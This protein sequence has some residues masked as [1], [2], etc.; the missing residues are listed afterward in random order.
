MIGTFSW[1]TLQWVHCKAKGMYGFLMWRYCVGFLLCGVRRLL[2]ELALNR[3][4][5]GC[6]SNTPLSDCTSYCRFS[7]PFSLSLSLS[8]S[9]SVCL[10]LC[11]SLSLSPLQIVH[12]GDSPSRIK[13]HQIYR[14]GGSPMSDSYSRGDNLTSRQQVRTR[15]SLRSCEHVHV[16]I[17]L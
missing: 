13:T 10:S 1:H 17:C 6:L 15:H 9:L 16:H 3:L 2:N 14:G 5:Y 8:L 11:L 4:G 7:S 12:A